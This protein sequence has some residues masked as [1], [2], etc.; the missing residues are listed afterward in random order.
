MERTIFL[1]NEE[2][3]LVSQ[4]PM[5]KTEKDLDLLIS[6]LKT[7]RDRITEKMFFY[8]LAN[9]FRS[10]S[11]CDMFQEKVSLKPQE[12]NKVSQSE[13]DTSPMAKE[14]TVKKTVQNGSTGVFYKD[15]TKPNPTSPEESMG[16]FYVKG[17]KK[18]KKRKE[19]KIV[20]GKNIESNLLFR[21]TY[22]K[23][24]NGFEYGLS[25]W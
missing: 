21:N 5:V 25:D 8:I 7:L 11:L 15:D 4:L 16:T 9:N 12:T 1:S 24:D 20:S 2:R 23:K 19:G 3:E 18:K 13:Q 6:K 22:I 14:K 10:R 17:W